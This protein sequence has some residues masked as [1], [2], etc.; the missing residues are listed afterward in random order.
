MKP[1]RQ[2]IDEYFLCLKALGPGESTLNCVMT[3]AHQS[4]TGVNGTF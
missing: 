3:N 4:P 2:P 1:W